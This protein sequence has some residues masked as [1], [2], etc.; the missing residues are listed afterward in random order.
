MTQLEDIAL[1]GPWRRRLLLAGWLLAIAII[2]ARAGQVQIVQAADWRKIAEEQ[3]QMDASLAAPRGA[4]L[5]RDGTQLAVSRERFKVSLAPG[6][7]TEPARVRKILGEDLGLSARQVASLTRDGREWSVVPGRISPLEVEPLRGLRGVYLERQLERFY[8]HGNLARGVLGGLRD[9]DGVGGIERLFEE[10]LSGVPGLEVLARDNSGQPIPGE[11]LTLQ[12]PE[13][14]GDVVLTLDMSLQEIA[15]EA[16]LEA[17]DSTGAAGGDVLMTDPKT[18]EILALVSMRGG[19]TAALSAI[20]TP[21]EPGSTLKPFTVAGLLTEGIASLSD[22]VDVGDGRWSIDGR[23]LSDVHAEGRMSIGD[24]LRVSSNV[25]I[26]MA[27]QGLSPEMHYRALRDFG[28]GTYTGVQLPGEVT[29]TLRRPSRWTAQSNESL[30]IGYEMSVTPVQMAMAYGALANGGLLMEPRLVRET[31]DADGTVIQRSSP[32]VVRRVVTPEVASDISMAL[33]G[34]VEAGTGTSAQL[35]T[36]RVAGKSGTSRLAAAGGYEEGAYNSSFV[37]FFPAENPQ[38][39]VFVKL[40]RPDGA[41]YGGAVAAPVT[42]RTM[43]AALATRRT[44]LDRGAL[45]RAETPIA[46]SS[47]VASFALLNRSVTS[48]AVAWDRDW[49]AASVAIRESGERVTL[50]DVSGLPSRVAARR[51]HALGL[52]VRPGGTG[53]LLGT[54]PGAGTR[55]LPGDTISLRFG[56]RSDD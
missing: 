42:R 27:A 54:V 53:Y 38:L 9:G 48:S 47:S 30:A 39:V 17:I 31:R 1:P 24:A 3:H 6:Q 10:A 2:C 44:P 56:R 33:E 49:D 16:L 23:S 4:I 35:A 5:D 26:A 7:L 11:R 15:Q 28:F 22:T 19:S 46:A 51:L 40:E 21:F 13:A 34:V 52:R 37:G 12:T 20:N 43:E 41:Y 14:G 50:P 18:G 25:G 36:F 8:P 32:R 55:V 29:G 45:V